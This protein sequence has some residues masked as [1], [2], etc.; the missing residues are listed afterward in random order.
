MYHGWRRRPGSA[1]IASL[2]GAKG[3]LQEFGRSESARGWN[4]AIGSLNGGV[5]RPQ[6]GTCDRLA[7]SR[8]Q[9]AM[10]A[11]F[12]GFVAL[13][14]LPDEFTC[15]WGGVVDQLPRHLARPGGWAERCV[16]QERQ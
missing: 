10:E 13:V 15:R 5:E 2:G 4:L 7:F 3:V 8:R 6:Y 16:E 9:S 14:D 1:R 12:R 11:S